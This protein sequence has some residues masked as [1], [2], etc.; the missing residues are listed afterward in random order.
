MRLVTEP[1]SV[2]SA[3]NMKELFMMPAT[4]EKR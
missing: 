3:E 1:F 4:R 2:C